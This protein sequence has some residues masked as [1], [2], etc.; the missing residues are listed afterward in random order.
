MAYDGKILALARDEIAE[1]RRKNDAE[2]LRRRTELFARQ[3][4]L[5]E[6]ETEITRLMTGVST[7]ALQRGE[8][9]GQAVR[10]ARADCEALERRRV[11]LLASLGLP[12]D[13]LD[14][15]FDCPHCRDT[16]YVL[17]QPCVCLLE[18]YRAKAVEALSATLRTDGQ[19]FENFDLS[20]YDRTPGPDGV[21]PFEKMSDICT[22][23]RDYA[24]SFGPNSANLLFQGSTGL[25]KTF[26]AA[27]IAKVVSGNGHSVVY[28]TIVSVM[29]AFESRKFDRGGESVGEAAARV[30]RC[31]DC[32]LLILDDLGTEMTTV[33][34]QSALYTLLNDRLLSGGRTIVTTNLTLPEIEKRYTPQIVSRLEDYNLLSF[35][36]RDIRALRREREI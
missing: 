1:R 4:A 33:F 11:Q 27:C 15:H 31:F 8:N 19:S 14:E 13:Y 6:I 21:S 35:V 3:P 7:A 24:E 34:T 30:R 36:G 29:E 32:E 18:C 10:N 26:L 9:V 25:G 12:A 2:H 16:G 20:Y 22:L 5:R 17:G 23:C 28:D